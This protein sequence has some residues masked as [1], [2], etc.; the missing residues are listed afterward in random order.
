MGHS[1][2]S[3]EGD[4]R[5]GYGSD[6]AIAVRYP[7]PEVVGEFVVALEPRRLG[8]LLAMC[9]WGLLCPVGDHASIFESMHPLDVVVRERARANVIFRDGPHFGGD[10]TRALATICSTLR[11]GGIAGARALQLRHT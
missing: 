10:A 5:E 11:T 3:I 1:E 6:D 7:M 4:G 2:V 9:S 8:L